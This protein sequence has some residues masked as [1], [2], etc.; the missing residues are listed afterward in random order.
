ME[1]FVRWCSF[2]AVV[3]ILVVSAPAAQAGKVKADAYF[4]Y[5]R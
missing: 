3:G 5:S 1:R 4:G 2:L